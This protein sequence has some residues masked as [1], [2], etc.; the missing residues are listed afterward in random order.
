VLVCRANDQAIR[1]RLEARALDGHSPSDTR[2]K[3]WPA[4]RAAFVEPNE[5]G[6]VF[7]ADT[8]QPLNDLVAAVV[9]AV[10][11]SDPSPSSPTR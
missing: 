1:E 11:A 5:T 7:N 8:A 3:L 10:R 4:V 6:T 2:L 9:A